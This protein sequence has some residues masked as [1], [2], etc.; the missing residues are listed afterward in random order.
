MSPLFLTL[1]SPSVHPVMMMS[2]TQGVT[3][4]SVQ[5]KEFW[6]KPWEFKLTIVKK[7]DSEQIKFPQG[8]AL[9]RLGLDSAVVL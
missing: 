6:E 1:S 8:N 9:S 2:Y 5:I 4:H 7:R 3:E